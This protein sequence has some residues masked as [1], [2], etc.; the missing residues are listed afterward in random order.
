M[1]P[2]PTLFATV[3]WCAATASA[4]QP[5]VRA[6]ERLGR[7]LAELRALRGRADEVGEQDRG[8]AGVRRGRLGGHR[9]GSTASAPSGARTAAQLGVT[10]PGLRQARFNWASI[11]SFTAVAGTP[12][13]AAAGPARSTMTSG[14]GRRV[15]GQRGRASPCTSA[16]VERDHVHAA[17]GSRAPSCASVQPDRE[18]AAARAPDR[19][20]ARPGRSR[21][22]GGCR[23]C[24]RSRARARRRASSSR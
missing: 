20:T 1:I 4:Q 22:C 9:V 17:C 12:A 7:L 11:R 24:A 19:G 16:R 5:V 3:P 6:P 13:S 10:G 18:P 14:P 23:R 21:A 8:G 2:S 15:V